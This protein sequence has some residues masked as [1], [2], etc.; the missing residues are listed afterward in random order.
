VETPEPSSPSIMPPDGKL[1]LNTNGGGY[2]TRIPACT[3]Y[4]R[5]CG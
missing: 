2:L 5:A 3:R 4:R 1:P